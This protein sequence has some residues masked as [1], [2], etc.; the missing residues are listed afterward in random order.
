MGNLLGRENNETRYPVREQRTRGLSSSEYIY[1]E[2]SN[3]NDPRIPLYSQRD[4]KL[5]SIKKSKAVQN[6]CHIN[7]LSIHYVPSLRRIKFEY[8]CIQDSILNIY[9]SDSLDESLI[10]TEKPASSH[11]IPKSLNKEIQIDL[12]SDLKKNFVLEIKPK[13]HSSNS[14]GTTQLT[15]C[16][17]SSNKKNDVLENKIEIKRQCVLYNGKAFEIQNIFGLSNN[18][19]TA[20]KNNEDSESCVICL[21]NNRETILLPCRHACLCTV[22]SETLFKNT[23]D[24]P[25]CR[26]SVLGVVNIENNR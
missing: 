15:F 18:S 9:N 2:F 20:S 26:N 1:S 21:T 10:N 3:R 7:G 19:I 8:D 13:N 11:H 12:K 17:Q 24:C 4:R 22:C 14:A 6:Q 5:I 23:Q 16:E 25:V